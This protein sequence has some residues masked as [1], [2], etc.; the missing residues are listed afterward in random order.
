MLLARPPAYRPQCLSLASNGLGADVTM[1]TSLRITWLVAT[2]F[3][4]I[5]LSSLH[6]RLFQIARLFVLR[7]DRNRQRRKADAR[8]RSGEE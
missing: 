8:T 2:W 1:K 6:G 3:R 4:Q 5:V 7:E